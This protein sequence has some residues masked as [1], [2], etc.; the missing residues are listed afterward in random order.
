L[1]FKVAL[2]TSTLQD[3][4]VVMCHLTTYKAV[5]FLFLACIA[6]KKEIIKKEKGKPKA[7]V[8]CSLWFALYNT[9]TA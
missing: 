9:E 3:I 5:K 2:L 4:G 1:D 6:K 8:V 7:N